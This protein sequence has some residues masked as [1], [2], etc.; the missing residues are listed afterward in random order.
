MPALILGRRTDVLAGNDLAYLLLA[1]FPALPA[2]ERNL[3][4]WIVLDPLAQELFQDWK[5]VASD[6]CRGSA[7][8]GSP[9]ADSLPLL[10]SFGARKTAN[11]TKNTDTSDTAKA[12]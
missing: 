8:P 12:T 1:D 2:T 9:S 3:T 5:T 7:K 10:G 6:A 4:R 11:Y